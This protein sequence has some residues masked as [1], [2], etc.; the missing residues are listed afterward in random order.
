MEGK[1]L[2]LSS[3]SLSIG[4]DVVDIDRFE[5]VLKRKPRFAEKY[6]HQEELE[7]LRN[8]KNFT[9]HLAGRFAAKEA[10]VK[11]MGTGFSGFSLKEII[12]LN[13]KS[14][15]PLVRLE[16]KALQVCKELGIEEFALSISFSK[17]TVVASAVAIKRNVNDGEK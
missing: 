14:G 13:D 7:S 10:I 8:R 2:M 1:A 12:V 15:K 17:N 4:I 5:G 16:G 9:R 11:A 6:F 3:Q